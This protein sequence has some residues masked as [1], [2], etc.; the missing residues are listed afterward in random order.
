M[1]ALGYAGWSPGQLE[2][3]MVRHGWHVTPG[4]DA[5]IFETPPT[6]R[7][8][9]AFAEAGDT[10]RWK[11]WHTGRLP[12]W[13]VGRLYTLLRDG[14]TAIAMLAYLFWQ[15]WQLTL[16]SMITVTLFAIIRGSVRGASEIEHTQRESD[17]M[18]R[19]IELCR[20]TFATL[21]STATLT[22]E[23]GVTTSHACGARSTRCKRRKRSA[24]P[25]ASACPS[26]PR[27]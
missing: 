12:T 9:A 24:S 3:E 26:S 2:D 15:N 14:T 11:I 19:F 18:N 6:K 17:S 20:R 1:V 27:R 10:T 25:R 21:P 4:S 8:Q 7:W 22:P 13:R 23:A 5:L 16:L